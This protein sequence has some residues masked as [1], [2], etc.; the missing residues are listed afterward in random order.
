VLTY[1]VKS[2]AISI[3]EEIFWQFVDDIYDVR[4]AKRLTP[5]ITTSGNVGSIVGA[6][7]LAC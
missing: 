3:V 7:L 4:E 5:V 6:G 2:I 1:G